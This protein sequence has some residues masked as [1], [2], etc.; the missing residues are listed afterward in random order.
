MTQMVQRWLKLLWI[1]Q[2][3]LDSRFMLQASHTTVGVYTGS[4]VVTYCYCMQNKA[5]WQREMQRLLNHAV[6]RILLHPFMYYYC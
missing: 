1:E 6:S 5:D 2:M 3:K 4:D